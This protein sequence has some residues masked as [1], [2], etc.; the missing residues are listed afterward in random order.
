MTA[1]SWT[2]WAGCTTGGPTGGGDAAAGGDGGGNGGAGGDGGA[3]DLPPAPPDGNGSGALLI[4]EL[5]AD[6]DGFQI[7]ET[8]QTEDWIE[9]YNAGPAPLSLAGF[10]LSEDKTA[11]EGRRHALPAT[12]LAPGATMLFWADGA[13]GEGPRHLGFKLGAEGGR[14]ILRG[15][16]GALADE[17]SYPALATNE[18]FARFSDGGSFAK[19]R[20]ATPGRD[21][22]PRCRPPAPPELPRE[23]TFA[24]YAGPPIAAVLAGPLAISELALEP[25][26]F[27]EVSNLSAAPVSLSD[28]DLRLVAHAPGRVLPGPNAGVALALPAGPLA[29]GASVVVALRAEELAAL[30]APAYEG[31]LG[32]FRKANGQVVQHLEFMRLPQA[33]SLALVRDPDG[34]GRYRLCSNPTPGADNRGC[35]AMA[36]RPIG[37]RVRQLVAEGDLAALAEGGTEVDNVAAK[38]VVDME[39]GDSVHFLAARRWPLHY[40]FV[41]E[42][43]YGQPPLN[44]CDP[45]E[46]QEFQNGWI[47]FSNREYYTTVGRRFLLAT[48]VRH[49]GSGMKTIE[50]DRSDTITAAQMRRAFFAIAARLPDA[51]TWSI[52]AQGERQVRA[53]KE[54]EGTVPIVDGAAPFRG[55]SFQALTP[56]IGFGVLKFIPA[57]ELAH[58]RLGLDVIAVTDDVPNDVPLLGGLVTEAFQTPLSHVAILTRNRGTP[59]MALVNA[60]NDARLGGLFDKLVRI[61]VGGGGFSVRAAS[62]AEAQAFWDKRRPQGPPLVPRL[63]RSLRGLVDLRARSLADLPAL[64]AKSAQMAELFRVSAIDPVCAGPIPT[65]K[66]A[67]GVPLVHGLEH[68]AASGA[69]AILAQGQARAD[70]ATDRSV[71]TTVLTEVRAAIQSHSPDPALVSAIET[72]AAR[73]FGNRRFRL[74]SSSNTEDLT[75]FSGAGLYTSVSA[76]LGDP[77][78]TVAD[79][80]RAV[81]A[82]LWDERAYEERALANIDQ[83]QVAMGVLIHEAYNGVE[84]ANGVVMSRDL[85]DPIRA[86]VVTIN[87]QA[88]EASVTN[89]APGVTSEEVTYSWWKTPPDIA[90]SRSSLIPGPVL[91]PGEM[92]RIACTIRAIDT[93][94]RERLDPTHANRWFT[95]ESEWKLVG[96]E[97]A[98]I[99]KQARPYAFGAATIPVDCREF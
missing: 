75:T 24:P 31:A 90:R 45:I 28:F 71:R 51:A 63:D 87:A 59:N 8:G 88:G 5:C 22:G 85:H 70:F 3:T 54:I 1:L 7:D 32:L 34:G 6:D 46:A 2:G 15:P 95:M 69:A 56:G 33:A 35:T 77:E 30:V 60:R 96:P 18:A 12:T 10:S 13:P 76:A 14:V 80:L 49:G 17:V 79:G 82:S 42:Q 52:R 38:A 21:N 74:R 48:L 68:F 36:A 26:P 86:S 9:L 16:D 94:F 89:P 50:F 93:H 37:D 62:T 72:M 4:N 39:A 81:W 84:R 11:G 23:E 55:V 27:V 53:L 40:T 64:G 43:I 41:R 97:R 61:E 25:T 29:P 83:S 20:Y 78:R 99:V 58:A 92:A 67:Y 73:A 19:C 57:N 66:E 98:L 65:P 44:R 91:T 47:E